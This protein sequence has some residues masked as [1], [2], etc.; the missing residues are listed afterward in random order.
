METVNVVSDDLKIAIEALK[1]IKKEEGRVCCNFELCT[2][3]ACSSSYGAWAIAD[4]ALA[5]LK[6]AQK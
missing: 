1:K 4:E 2:H 6:E 3:S 5:K